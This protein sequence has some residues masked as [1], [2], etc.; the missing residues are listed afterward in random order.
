VATK[1][2]RY[3]PPRLVREIAIV[4]RRPL[5][6][7][8]AAHVAVRNFNASSVLK[9]RQVV[10]PIFENAGVPALGSGV[11]PAGSWYTVKLPVY[12]VLHPAYKVPADLLDAIVYRVGITFP[13][14]ESHPTIPYEAEADSEIDT[15]N[16]STDWLW[17]GGIDSLGVSPQ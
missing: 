17:L 15:D 2:Y 5:T 4:K 9:N 11:N 10:P 7:D 6:L 3:E 13:S 14:H 12:S 16:S 1:K 8:V